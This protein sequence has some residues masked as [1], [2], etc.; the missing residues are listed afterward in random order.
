MK[1]ENSVKNREGLQ[2]FKSPASRSLTGRDVCSMGTS[3]RENL[4]NLVSMQQGAANVLPDNTAC[5]SGTCRTCG[6]AFMVIPHFVNDNRR[7]P[8]T[9][10]RVYFP[11]Y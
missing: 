7:T 11:F 3:L 4:Y 9:K 2:D 6:I 1:T 5:D 8:G 10:Q